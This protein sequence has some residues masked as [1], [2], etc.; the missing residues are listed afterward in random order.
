MMMERGLSRL[1]IFFLYL[2]SLL[3]FWFLYLISEIL[4]VVLYYITHYRRRVVQENLRNSFPEKAEEERKIIEK[5][6]FRYLADFIVETIKTISISEQALRRRVIVTNPEMISDYYEKGRSVIVVGGHYCNWEFAGL[7]F[8]FYTDKKFM[9]VYK[10]LSNSVFDKFFLN[11]RSRFGTIP[12]SMKQTLRKMVEYKNELTTIAFLSDQT[13]VREDA[14]YFA[15]FLHQPTAVFL[16]IEKLAK[17][18]DKVVLYYDMRR[19]K[20]GYY[21][22]TLTNLFANPAQTVPY[23]ITEAHVKQLELTIRKEPQYWLWSHRRWKF[24]PEDIQR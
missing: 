5:K 9:I 10:P 15:N 11:I 8:Q 12:V 18:M 3:P 13:P 24:K 20:R 16:G 14:V 19:I 6:F 2:I 4:F 22:C 21:T 1:G 17:S 23:E 7:G